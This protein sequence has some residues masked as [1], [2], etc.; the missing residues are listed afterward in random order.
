MG[1]NHTRSRS[2]AQCVTQTHA[3]GEEMGIPLIPIFPWGFHGNGNFS[4]YI[5]GNNIGNGNKQVTL[6][7]MGF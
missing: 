3:G 2:A 5:H 6:E 4:G 1:A 7:G